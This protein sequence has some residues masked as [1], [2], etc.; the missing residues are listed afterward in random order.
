MQLIKSFFKGIGKIISFINTYFK[1]FVFLFIVFLILSPSKDNT[2]LSNANLA[3]IN[4]KGEINDASTLLEQIYKLKDDNAIKGVLFYI[5][6][7]GGA[8]A[9]SMEIALAIQDLK[10]KKPVV[11]YAG[12]TIASGSYLSA[13]GANMIIANPASFVGSI[14]VIMQGFNASELAQKIGISDQTIKA[15]TY[16]EAGTFMRKWSK[17]EKEFLQNLANQSYILFT[18]FVAKNRNLD[19]NQTKSW[20]DAKVFLANEALKLKLIDKVGNYELAKKEVEKLAKVKNPI[21]QKEDAIDKFLKRL[22]E[23]SASFF[24]N[25]LA[26]FF[27]QVSSQKIY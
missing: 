21:W 8:F 4:L 11:A 12:G 22:E 23:Q 24:A 15:G 2:K 1:T 14:G 5:D 6:S 16:K 26:Q 18:N 10:A 19:L 27:T 13:V 9:P 20:A 3:Q 17:E 7:P 25:T